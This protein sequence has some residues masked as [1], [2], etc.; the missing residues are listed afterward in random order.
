MPKYWSVAVD[1]PLDEALTYLDPEREDCVIQRGVRVEVPLGKRTAEGVV[2]REVSAPENP[3]FVLKAIHSVNNEH[4]PLPEAYLLWAE[5][6]AGYYNYPLGD[7]LSA[8]FPSLKKQTKEKKSTK[9]PLIKSLEMFPPPV[10]MDEQA[11]A[12]EAITENQ[13]FATHL[14]FGVTGSGKTEVYLEALSKVLDQGKS[15]LFLVP[16]I[17]LTPQLVQRFAR[18]FGDKI[19]ILHSQ[20]TDRERTNQWW[21]IQTGKK[22]ILIGARSALF[23]PMK[24]LGLILIDEE[25]EPSFKQEE[26]LKYHARDCSI[27]LG[28]FFDCPVV[29][30]SATPSLESWNNAQSGKYQLHRLTKRARAQTMP[31]IHVIDLRAKEEADKDAPPTGDKLPNWISK[32]LYDGMQLTLQRGEQTALFLNRRGVSPTVLCQA[33][34]YVEECPNCDISLTLH[35]HNHLVCHYC[36]YHRSLSPICPECR[37]GE[38]KPIGLGTEQVEADVKKLFPEA[39]VARAD[40]DEV[41]SREEMEDLIEKMENKEIDFLIGTQMIA[42]GLDFPYLTLVGFV[43]ADVGFNL[44][45]FRSS[46][47]S[48]QLL[49]QMSGRSGRHVKVGERPGQVIIQ[50]YNPLHLSVE[51]AKNHDYEGFVK[52]E[53]LA[54]EGLGYPPYGRLISIRFQ[55]LHKDAVERGAEIFA[56]RAQLLKEKNAQFTELQVLGPAEA[57]LARLRGQYRIHVLLKAKQHQILNRCYRVLKGDAAWL[58]S[59]VRMIVDVDPM[60]L[61]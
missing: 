40:R 4:G 16:E 61:L 60:N 45:D 34:G 10:L 24:N 57:P 59:G 58:P 8:A 46:E 25:H 20:L 55:G 33:C 37:E 44:P 51:Y 36:D 42:K 17:S 49:T 52:E 19:A 53:L 48:F 3:Q 56:N 29:L 14:L 1:A 6:L 22:P 39:R 28:K 11:Q 31:E 9:A 47:R 12:V 50:T 13:T 43:L 35:G 38:L 32:E 30:G 2:I 15:G 23:C 21:D 5:W 26:K 27:M 41:Q 7:V 18:R 54:R